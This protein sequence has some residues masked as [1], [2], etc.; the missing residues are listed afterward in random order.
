[1][2]FFRSTQQEEGRRPVSTSHPQEW[3][4]LAWGVVKGTRSTKAICLGACP[5][6]DQAGSTES[7]EPQP[8]QFVRLGQNKEFNQV[9]VQM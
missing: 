3:G 6:D 8:F 5:R 7:E 2:G 1:M 4:E 9:R